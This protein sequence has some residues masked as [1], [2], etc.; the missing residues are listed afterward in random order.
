MPKFG[1][2][3]DDGKIYIGRVKSGPRAGYELWSSP[4]VAERRRASVRAASA[5][6]AAKKKVRLA[7][8]P[9][10]HARYNA[11]RDE[12]RR[13]DYRM[14]MLARAKL[15]ASRGG[16]TCTI[17]KDDIPHVTHCPVLGVELTIGLGA[18]HD[19]SPTLDKIR[20]ELGY[21]KGNVIV[22]SKLA[23]CI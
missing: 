4:E 21:V 13:A 18:I 15:R 5:S 2:T 10:Y 11:Q 16:Y 1:D 20:P 14:D 23:N 7:T 17:T 19:F 3:R 8:D 9:E 12:Y 6:N 22:V